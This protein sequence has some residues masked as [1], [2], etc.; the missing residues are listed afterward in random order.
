MPLSTSQYRQKPYKD[1]TPKDR[2]DYVM[3]MKRLHG[4]KMKKGTKV[5][6]NVRGKNVSGTINKGATKQNTSLEIDIDGKLVRKDLAT[7]YGIA[8]DMKGV[9]EAEPPKKLVGMAK[10]SIEPTTPRGLKLERAGG[11]NKAVKSAGTPRTRIPKMDIKSIIPEGILY[12][13]A[14]GYDPQLHG[15][16]PTNDKMPYPYEMYW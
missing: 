12:G 2:R 1:H 7:I 10:K 15:S 14:L 3:N 6:V 8:G 4:D 16:D 5:I 11:S 13:G 9:E